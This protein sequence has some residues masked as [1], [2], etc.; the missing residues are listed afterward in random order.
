M[1]RGSTI[2]AEPP[3]LLWLPDLGAN[4]PHGVGAYV[5]DFP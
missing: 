1:T 3:F 4:P 2:A 5:H